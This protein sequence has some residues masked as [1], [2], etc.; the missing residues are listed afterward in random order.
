MTLFVLVVVYVVYR[1]LKEPVR[2]FSVTVGELHCTPRYSSPEEEYE[3]KKAWRL[4]TINDLYRKGHLTDKKMKKL[5]E[6]L[7]QMKAGTWKGAIR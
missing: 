5:N 2:G 6:E 7:D 3:A 4:E 1:I